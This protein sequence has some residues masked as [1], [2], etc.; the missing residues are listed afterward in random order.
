MTAAASPPLQLDEI[1][2]IVLRNRPSP[3]VG[4]YI[5]LRIDDRSSARQ[6]MGRLTEVVDSAADWWQPALPAILNV[7]LTYPGLEA[8]GVPPASLSSF[9]DEFRQGMA[10]RAERLGDTGESGPARWEKPFG[11]G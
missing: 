6:L 10:A 8:L 11:T 3:Y 9:P 5:L 1:Q 2:G 4:T 7:G